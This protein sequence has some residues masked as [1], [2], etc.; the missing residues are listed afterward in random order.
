MP[1]HNHAAEENTTNL[2]AAAIFTTD[3]PLTKA[4]YCNVSLP[5]DSL[6]ALARLSVLEP[7]RYTLS[8]QGPLSATGPWS[9]FCFFLFFFS[10]FAF[11]GCDLVL[12]NTSNKPKRA[13]KA[14]LELAHIKVGDP[15]SS[16]W[17]SAGSFPVHLFEFFI[18]AWPIP[19]S[20]ADPFLT[21]TFLCG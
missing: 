15:W 20:T 5:L 11:K 9:L 17:S 10:Y 6:F 4:F 18:C 14:A 21:M 8:L 16:A 12:R 13:S 7:C 1:L 2:D 3:E 19:P